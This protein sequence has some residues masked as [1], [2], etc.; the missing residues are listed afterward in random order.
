MNI[1]ILQRLLL[2]A[3]LDLIYYPV[4]WYT[5]GLKF[6]ALRC[7]A[8]LKA[9]NA[10]LAPGLWLRYILVP[11]FGQYDIQG[12]IISFFMRFFNVL[13]RSFALA[14]WLAVCLWLLSLW[15]FIPIIIA[16]GFSRS[17]A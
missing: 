2:E 12:R 17:A 1:I 3:F 4:W 14:V 15:L 13:A 6:E 5:G 16:W 8:F 11:M 10:R 7:F 9:G